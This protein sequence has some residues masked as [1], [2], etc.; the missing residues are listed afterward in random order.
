MQPA[1]L[2]R[3]AQATGTGSCPQISFQQQAGAADTLISRHGFPAVPVATDYPS[4]SKKSEE[5]MKAFN[6]VWRT[7]RGVTLLA[8]LAVVFVG[9]VGIS[10]IARFLMGS[11]LTQV[12]G[13]LHLTS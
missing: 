4:D 9:V 6:L 11:A 8:V 5:T 12:A 13:K 1:E 2:A 7:V 3:I 10:C